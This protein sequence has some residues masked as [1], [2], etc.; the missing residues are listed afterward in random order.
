M[1]Y[2]EY[3]NEWFR[4]HVATR[5]ITLNDVINFAEEFAYAKD[6]LYA[7][8]FLEENGFGGMIFACREEWEDMEEADA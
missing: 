8:D 2:E 1:T 3:K 5:Q 4:D 6:A 7:A